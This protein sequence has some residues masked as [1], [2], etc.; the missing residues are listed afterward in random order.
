MID[1]LNLATADR[2]A[3]E[4]LAAG[5][6]SD[7]GPLTVAILDTGAHP[8]VLKREDGSEFLRV[9]VAIGKAYG[10][11]GMGLPGRVM[12]ER[13]PSVPWFFSALS[14]MSNGRVVPV[15]G[16][17]LIRSTDGTLLGA[18]GV[19]GDTSDRDEACA[20][21]GIVAVDLLAD[22]GQVPEWRRP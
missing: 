10:A 20:I 14:D 18:A 17:V 16:S 4:I 8:I 6:R 11:L 22:Y 7:C 12:A 13:V 21:E 2:I 1:R 5:R 3:D 9:S 15:P 19:S